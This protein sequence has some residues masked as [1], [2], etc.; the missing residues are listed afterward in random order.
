MSSDDLHA[1]SGPELLDRTRAL[2]AERNRIDAA[3]ARTVRVA[4]SRRA[5]AADGQKTAASWLRGHGR[6]S[7]PAASKI[8]R[9]GRALEQLP[10]VE[11][12]HAAGALTADQVDVIA[13]FTG[14]KWAPRIAAQGGTVADVAEVLARFAADRPHED[15]T[16][17]AH[18]VQQRLDQDGPEPDPTE[19]RFLTI[20]RHAD[21]SVTFRGHLDALGAEKVQAALEAHRQADRPAGDDRTVSQQQGDALVQWADNTLAAGTAPLLRR[22]KPQ[23]AVK[24]S[25]EDLADEATGRG[26]ADLG[27]GGVVSAATARQVACDAELRR[28]LIGPDGELL[29]LGRSQRLATPALRRAVE[30]RDERCVFAGCD[31]PTSWCDVHHVVHWLFG[32]Q[33]SLENSALLCER[34]HTQV[35]HGFTIER[36]TAGRW[37]TYRPDGTEI[38]TL[39]PTPID[40]EQEL[41]HAG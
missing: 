13:Q 20:V 17:L 40:G 22:N 1:L 34:H 33:T 30:H 2:V 18:Q 9:A 25:S 3:L 15:L 26:A 29:D 7:E 31:A 41:A 23:V 32:G 27:F 24:V 8:V 39:R 6:L 12:L 38:L 11:E 19:E 37:H 16:R 14:P 21:G 35:H 4:D 36:D 10:A 28:Y 5:F